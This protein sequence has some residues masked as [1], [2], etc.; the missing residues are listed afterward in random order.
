MKTASKLKIT[1]IRPYPA[2]GIYPIKPSPGF[3]N[4]VRLSLNQN[5]N[6]F[7]SL[8]ALVY[9]IKHVLLLLE[10]ISGCGPSVVQELYTVFQRINGRAINCVYQ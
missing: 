2:L 6:S 9:V 7:R 4:L 8:T 3:P 10:C 1:M 5:K